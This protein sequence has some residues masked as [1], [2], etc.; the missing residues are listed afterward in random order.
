MGTPAA[1]L[2]APCL[3]TV[4][5]RDT[6][7]GRPELLHGADTR[8]FF[9]TA[10]DFYQVLTIVSP[11]DLKQL[12]CEGSPDPQNVNFASTIQSTSSLLYFL[13]LTGH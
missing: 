9:S 1:S 8:V 11:T 13:S 5:L 4:M 10:T 12:L 7:L 3:L 2:L 6:N